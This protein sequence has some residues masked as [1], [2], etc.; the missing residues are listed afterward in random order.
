VTNPKSF[1]QQTLVLKE[2]DAVPERGAGDL[3]PG[4]HP[5]EARAK[6]Q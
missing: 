6:Q 5:D 1:I 2:T 3:A 4:S